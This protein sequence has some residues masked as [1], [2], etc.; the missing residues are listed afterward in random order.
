MLQWKQAGHRV[1]PK[2]IEHHHY[3]DAD[4]ASWPLKV[5]L[6]DHIVYYRDRATCRQEGL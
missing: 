3:E 5:T 6:L 1:L 2:D 4:N